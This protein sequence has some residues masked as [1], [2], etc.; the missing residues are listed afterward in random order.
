MKPL[1]TLNW[2]LRLSLLTVVLAACSITISDVTPVPATQAPAATEA[3]L[4][5]AA[6]APTAA[7]TATIAPTP[8]PWADL[9]LTGS[10]I[11]TQ[12]KLGVLKLN[13][14][15]GNITTLLVENDKMWLSAESISPDGQTIII[16]YSPPPTGDQVQLGYT[17]L[18]QIA[19]DGSTL[20][21]KPVL[22]QADPQESYF[23]PVWTP[24]GKYVYYAHFVPIRDTSGNTFKYTIERIEYPDGQP[25][26]ILQDAIWPVISPDGTKLAYLKFDTVQYTQELYLSDID[27]QNGA[28]VLPAGEFP[29]VDAQFFSPDGKTLVFNGVGEG[30]SPALSFL[31]QLLG[32]QAAQAHN[33]PSDW[34]S[35]QLDSADAKPIRLTTLYDTGM[36]GDF[37]PDGQ[38]IAFLS[39][40]GMYEMD[41]LGE[42]VSPLIQIKSLGTLEWVP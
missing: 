17:G 3:V 15:T 4:A 28:P 42:K 25:E 30:Q 41:P 23:T 29:S 26:V 39:A 13:L 31:D 20:E 9:N 7:P 18:Y 5:T 36:Y 21:P 16:A 1:Q 19:T 24:D 10:L 14:V 33:V 34:W 38:H 11:Y 6:D 12:G 2:G 35:I 40:S 27:G 22:P 32:V 37:S 8:V